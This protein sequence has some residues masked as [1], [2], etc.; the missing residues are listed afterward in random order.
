MQL[1]NYL[2]AIFGVIWQNSIFHWAALI[3]LGVAVW[4]EYTSVKQYQRYLGAKSRSTSESVSYLRSK[5]ESD[6]SGA[7]ELLQWET[8]ADTWKLLLDWF[9]EHLAG[10][11]TAGGEAYRTQVKSGRF[12]LFQ[13]PTI[14]G[15]SAPGVNGGLYRVP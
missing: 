1:I 10:E 4:G 8:P 11:I 6:T 3:L 2:T 15:R 9:G 5:S 12:V 7:I 14:L 13:Y